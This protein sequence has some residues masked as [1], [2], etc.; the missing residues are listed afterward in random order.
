MIDKLLDYYQR[1]LNFL[2]ELGSEF[3]SQHPKIAGRLR[4]DA[5]AI[6]DPHVS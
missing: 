6:E 5:D 4:L 1:E 3:A 2:R